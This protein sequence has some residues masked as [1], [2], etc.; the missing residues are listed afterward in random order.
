MTIDTIQ[1]GTLADELLRNENFNIL[2]DQMVEE[3]GRDIL[4]TPLDQWEQRDNLYLAF[5][6]G[7]MFI[8]TLI[9]Y[10]NVRDTE[11]LAR[12]QKEDEEAQ[13]DD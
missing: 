13:A 6:G 11:I 5:H 4:R 12:K 3:I 9:E 1:R 8:N 7:R 2:W 10:R